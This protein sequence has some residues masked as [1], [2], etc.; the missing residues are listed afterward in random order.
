ML[1][2][3]TARKIYLIF[4]RS[5]E[6]KVLCILAQGGFRTINPL[7]CN[8][9]IWNCK[10]LCYQGFDQIRHTTILAISPVLQNHLWFDHLGNKNVQQT[11]QVF[12]ILSYTVVYRKY[13]D[14]TINRLSV[15]GGNIRFEVRTMIELIKV[16]VINCLHVRSQ[17]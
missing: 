3:I 17:L 2:D 13:T 10:T 15:F 4:E 11:A 8:F 7:N 6:D 5:K 12:Y 14:H 16:V 9:E 1:R